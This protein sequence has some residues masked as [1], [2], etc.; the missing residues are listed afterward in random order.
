MSEYEID[1]DPKRVDLDAVWAFMSTEAYWGHWRTRE[2]VA[3]QIDSAWRVVGAYHRETGAQVGFARAVSDGV[4]YAY[5]A[6][7]YVL[8]SARGTGL[9]KALVRTMIDEGPGAKFRWALHTKDAH[10]LYRLFGFAEPTMTYLERPGTGSQ[11]R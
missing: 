10:D 9:G 6:D 8:Q 1:D 5:L 2:Q 3:A 7:V 4:G 11:L